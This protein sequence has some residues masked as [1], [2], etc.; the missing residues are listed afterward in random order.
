MKWKEIKEMGLQPDTIVEICYKADEGERKAIGGISDFVIRCGYV[1]RLFELPKGVTEIP[2][3]YKSSYPVHPPFLTIYY[4]L[5]GHNNTGRDTRNHR[6]E[7][8]HW[9]KILTRI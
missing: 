5:E 3:E 1:G 4:M 6:P 9:I 8:I 7:D 2:P